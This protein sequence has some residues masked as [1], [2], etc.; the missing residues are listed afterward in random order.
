[1]EVRNLRAYLA[2]VG[3][4]NKQFAEKLDCCPEYLRMI[5]SGHKIPGRRLARDIFKLT[6]GIIN[7]ETKKKRKPYTKRK[8]TEEEK[9]A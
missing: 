3:I 2:N 5:T 9:C 7:L 8:K 6:D 4:T 1:M